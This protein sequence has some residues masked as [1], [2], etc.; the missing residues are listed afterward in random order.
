MSFLRIDPD[1]CRKDNICVS[2]CPVKIILASTEGNIP[3][4]RN[5][6][7]EICL[8]CGHCVAACP[9]DALELEPLP[10]EKFES[11]E[12][13]GK[14]LGFSEENAVSFLKTRRSIRS[15]K[16]KTVPLETLESMVDVLRYAPSAKNERP[17]QWVIVREPKDTAHLTELCLEWMA[18]L[19]KDS[20]AIA[21][22]YG[23]SGVLAAWKRNKQDLVLNGAPH[24]AIAYTEESSVWMTTDASIALSY[25][26]L[27]AH[28]HGVGACFAGFF[29]YALNDSKKIKDFLN[30]PHGMT[31]HGAHMLGY[32][33]Y[34]YRK[35]PWRP[36][37][38][39]SW[40]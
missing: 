23:V 35:V 18:E 21:K 37:L 40:K 29:T 36:G 13:R 6:G 15:F 33:L 16:K 8:E 9:W 22:Q 19:R 17:T 26:E 31:I 1:K 20:P 32:A 5:G 39:V 3:I 7:E 28:A 25:L 10:K 4:L 38:G 24:V 30:I 14:N 2:E 11:I 27:A 34:A 12:N